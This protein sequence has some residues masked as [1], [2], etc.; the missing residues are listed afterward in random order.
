MKPKKTNTARRPPYTPHAEGQHIKEATERGY[1]VL[2]MDGPLAAHVVGKLEQTHTDIQFK[3]VD[4][5]IAEK[6]IEKDEE[7]SSALDEKQEETLEPS[8]KAPSRRRPQG[9]F[10]AMSPRRRL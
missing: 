6:L 2:V 7:L 10:A 3:R 8:S 4:A 1:T 5:D 9:Q